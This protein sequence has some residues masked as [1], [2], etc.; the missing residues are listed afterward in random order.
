MKLL[1]DENTTHHLLRAVQRVRPGLDVATVQQLGL[2]GADDEIVLDRAISEG[3]VLV[4]QDLT[5][6]PAAVTRRMLAGQAVPGV[7]VLRI[8]SVSTQTLIEDILLV[9]DAAGPDDWRLPSFSS[10]P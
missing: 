3:R 5:T 10:F 9:L 1:W 2:S 6:I 7:V 8:E 4:S